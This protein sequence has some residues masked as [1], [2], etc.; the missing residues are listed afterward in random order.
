MTGFHL[1]V[2]ALLEPDAEPDGVWPLYSAFVL[3]L[4]AAQRSD[5]CRPFPVPAC[6]AYMAVHQQL[7]WASWRR[8]KSDWSSSIALVLAIAVHGWPRLRNPPYLAFS[9]QQRAG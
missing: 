4:G 9:L 3:A 5:R 7:S 2:D 6:L 1:A 8:P